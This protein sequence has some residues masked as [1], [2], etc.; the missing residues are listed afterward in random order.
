MA[1]ISEFG[2]A[3][4]KKQEGFT[5]IGVVTGTEEEVLNQFFSDNVS[6]VKGCNLAGS[7]RFDF[8]VMVKL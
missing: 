2:T 8:F 7:D 6:L 3:E 1:T 5:G 4:I